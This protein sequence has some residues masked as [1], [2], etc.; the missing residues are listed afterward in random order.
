VLYMKLRQRELI[1]TG[2]PSD[3]WV[4]GITRMALKANGP[5]MRDCW[6]QN[7]VVAAFGI[8][9]TNRVSLVFF[10]ISW[11]GVRL[12]P[13]STSATIWPIVPAPDER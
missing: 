6:F 2:E 5:W 8:S 10:L 9:D 7:C 3:K 13:L 1:L 11:S 4:L 12:S